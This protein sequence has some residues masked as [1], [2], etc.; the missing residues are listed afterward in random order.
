MSIRDLKAHYR[1]LY[2]LHGD[3][4]DALQWSSAASQERRFERLVAHI[5]PTESVVDVGCGFGDLLRHLCEARGFR[6]HYLG[7]DFVEE[8][9]RT[10]R[11][12][13][14]A[15]SEYRL[16]DVTREELPAGHDWYVASGI[17]NNAVADN[18][19]LLRNVVGKMFAAARQGVSFNALSTHVDYQAEGLHYY[20]P[21]ALFDLCKRELTPYVSL[22]HAYEVKPGVIPFEFTLHLRKSPN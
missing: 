21:A 2:Q 22:D 3:S 13:A 9:L 1:S 17:F 8:F 12:D 14:R 4:H 16:L 7:L 19:G 11:H 18:A 10:G 15:T 6:G 5:G 20:D